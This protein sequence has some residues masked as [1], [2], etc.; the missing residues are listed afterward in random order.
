MSR[1]TQNEQSLTYDEYFALPAA[2]KMSRRQALD[3]LP[4]GWQA[5]AS[6]TANY[7]SHQAPL[8]YMLLAVA[9]AALGQYPLTTRVFLLRVICGVSAWSAYNLCRRRARAPAAVIAGVHCRRFVLHV[10]FTNVLGH[11]GTR[12]E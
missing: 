6:T 10:L 11:D 5:E 3:Q 7:E 4:A 9:D 1:F 12:C 2:Q 8:A